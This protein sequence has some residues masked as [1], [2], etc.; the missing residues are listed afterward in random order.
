MLNVL[1]RVQLAARF[2]YR[3]VYTF[4]GWKGTDREGPGTGKGNNPGNRQPT[5]PAADR[6]CL[7]YSSHTNKSPVVANGWELTN[8]EE[9]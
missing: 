5:P 8:F 7:S 6:Y 9:G 1:R 2:W 4:M 3:P